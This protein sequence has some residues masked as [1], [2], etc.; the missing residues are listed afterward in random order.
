MR[1]IITGGSGLIGQALAL[2]LSQNGYEVI[3]LSR[4]PE[5]VQNRLPAGVRAVLWDGKTATGWA[6][7]AD[8]S[9]AIVNLAGAN[10]SGGRWTNAQ[11]RLILQS[12]VEAGMA[13]SQ[14][15]EVVSQKP[16]VVVQSSAVDYYGPHGDE[17]LTEETP[18]GSGFLADV[19]AQ[20]EASTG[21]VE[22]AG[23]RRVIIRTGVVLSSRGGALP[24]MALP[25]HLFV[26]GPIGNG[27]QWFPWI[28]LVD[29]TSAIRFLIENKDASGVYNLSAPNPLTNKEFGKV[30][31]KVLHRPSYFP[32][33]AIVIKLLFGEMSMILLD[34]KRQVPE[35]LLKLGYK[36][37]YQ[38]AEQALMNIYHQR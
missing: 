2:E 4:T 37:S 36:F 30:L 1:I 14:A 3:V 23:V 11:K 29:E 17:L 16:E 27:G 34:G 28:S 35:R 21:S 33:P 25:Y 6:N 24:R 5:K 12:R 9:K 26:G 7:R 13:V 8:G 22:S 32:I 19:C 31:G 18:Q 15:I 38:Q 10:I 20:W